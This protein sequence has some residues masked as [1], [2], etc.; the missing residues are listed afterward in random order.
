MEIVFTFLCI[1][2]LIVI[3][4]LRSD[5]KKATKQLDISKSTYKTLFKTLLMNEKSASTMINQTLDFSDIFDI[6]KGDQ[7]L[8]PSSY[9][10]IFYMSDL[11]CNTC[12]E[13]EI[14][15][16]KKI[17]AKYGSENV[18]VIIEESTNNF[19]RS[20]IRKLKITFSVF[21][22]VNNAFSINNKIPGSPILLLFGDS[23]VVIGAN[24]PV[25][26]HG[27]FSAPFYELC[28]RLFEL[29]KMKAP[30]D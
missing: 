23:G 20:F 7:F 11:G 2:M 24:M 4:L 16:M 29:G 1:F 25:T 12:Q 26:G 22:S 8:Q 19:I 13:A 21:R 27:E 18:C 17:S 6:Q 10:I 14:E 30:H 5:I 28:I 3:I 9:K 15:Y